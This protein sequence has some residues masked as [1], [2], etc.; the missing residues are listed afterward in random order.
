[1]NKLLIPQQIQTCN[2]CGSTMLESVDFN[3]KMHKPVCVNCEKVE[4]KN[5]V[6]ASFF[7]AGKTTLEKPKEE[8]S[9]PLNHESQIQFIPVDVMKTESTKPIFTTVES[10]PI[11][12]ENNKIIKE[13]ENNK[14]KIWIDWSDVIGYEEIKF[15]IDSAINSTNAKKTHILI[16]GE[17]GT[18]KTVF[19][20]T[21]KDSLE[22][23]NVNVH[24]LDATTMSSSGVIEYLFTNNID[25][26]VLLI[27]E[28][29]K[30]EKQHQSCFLNMLESGML[31]ETKNKKIRSKSTHSVLCIATGNYIKK[32]MNP[33][34]TRF[35][36]FQI[37]EYTKEQ[38]FDIG[39]KLLE[40]KKFNKSKE[41]AEYI[42]KSIWDIYTK[43]GIKPNLRYARQVAEITNNDRTIIDKVLNAQ[44]KYSKNVDVQ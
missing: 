4:L 33:L 22:Q 24:Y 19:E 32:L 25:N 14:N 43:Q 42:V 28:I 8:L 27:D 38:F 17:A 12:E 20:L 6:N 31:Q 35:M 5:V 30:L 1:M 29:D 7:N 26:S 10:K 3:Y 2:N 36:T 21:V 11:Q 39:V 37:P 18:S 41:N 40:G 44:K 16:V 23:Q 13:P 9:I 15:I 34:L